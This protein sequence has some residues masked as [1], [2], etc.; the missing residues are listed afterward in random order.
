MLFFFLFTNILNSANIIEFVAEWIATR[1][2]A[3]GKP[4]VLA[5]LLMIASVVCFFMV[6]ATAACM[7]MIPLVKSIATLY[8]YKPGDK[9]PLLM[10]SGLVYIGCTS[11]LI[12]PYKSLPLVIFGAYEANTGDS[13]NLGPYM[14]IIAIST[15][16]A[17][18][19]FMFYCKFIAKPDVS[20]I[21][22]AQININKE[23]KLT[24]YQKFVLMFFVIIVLLLLVIPNLLPSSIGIV[25]V[26]QD[27][28]NVGILAIAVVCFVAF[29]LRGSVSFSQLFSKNVSW[30]L[31]FLLA[32][33]MSISNPFTDE[34]TGI[35]TWIVQFVTPLVSG[36]SPLMF[37]L[38][39]CVICCILTNLANNQAV[40]A[41]FTPIVLSIG[42]AMDA[43]LPTLIVCMMA[44]CNIGMITPPASAPGAMLHGDKEWIVGK[45]A[46][47]YGTLWSIV[48]LVITV[49]IIYPLG[50]ILL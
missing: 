29:Q 2:F 50:S 22:N 32:A 6:S 14:I 19:F 16:V 49:L 33:A 11:Y 47:T 31:I 3:Y 37:T 41:L 5:L 13:I 10:I 35:T 26:L 9:W 30:N 23:M 48:N 18:A 45:S 15:I 44:A 46:Y 43:N 21:A 8:G 4:W 12:L 27:I 20:K 25:K 42:T 40:G 38:I 1:K 17:L 34:S 28:G 24:S 7:V 39:I 36:K